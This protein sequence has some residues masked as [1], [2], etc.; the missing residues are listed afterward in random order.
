VNNLYI[1]LGEKLSSSTVN[2]L[3]MM[4]HKALQDAVKWGLL[5]RNVC[6]AV[7]A[8]RR[9]HFEMKPL[10]LE[11]AQLLLEAA[12]EDSLE[13]LWVLALT[14]GM[15]RGEVLALKWQDINFEQAILQVKRIFTR[16]PGRRYIESEPK[17]EKSKRGIKLAAV[18]IETLKQHRIR[19]LE[20]KLQAGPAWTDH[21]LVF[22]TALGTPLNPNYVLERFK[23]LL[24][25]AGLPDMRFH[26]MRHSVATI[27]LSM[28]TNPKVVQ[29]L[30]GHNRI[31]ETMDTYS[32]VLPA[33]HGEAIKRL[34]DVLWE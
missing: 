13:A 4:L 17:T 12:K 8:P 23:K 3:H 15:R 18:S 27:L 2:T 10:T 26:D 25:K 9:A 28:G 34:E 33:I 20:A 14:T 16:A 1:K 7:S 22:C 5:A 6:D 31:Q 32:H 29:E 24:K 19:Q 21:D 11:Q 30:L